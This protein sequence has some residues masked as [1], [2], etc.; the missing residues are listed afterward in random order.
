M[1]S[2]IDRYDQSALDY[3]CYWAPVLDA[4]S[5]RLLD[6][7][8]DHMAG[9]SGRQTI[10]DVGAGT[11]ALALTAA[12]RW[13]AA[14]VIVSDAA[15][16]MLELARQ[17]LTQAADVEPGRLTF[18]LAPA[19]EL[20]LADGSVDLVI[21]SFVLQ[22]VPDR[23]AAL[24]EA[25][26]VLRP[27]GVLAYVTWLDRE[28]S[29]PFEPMYEFDEAVLDLGIDEP[30]EEPE[31]HAGDVL[32]AR[33]AADQ[34]RRAGFRSVSAREDELV[35]DWTAESYL[36]YKLA[37]D[38]RALLSLLDERQRRELE[39]NARARLARLAPAEFRWYAPIVF[40]RGARPLG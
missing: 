14:A 7:V 8:S 31:A 23:L 4:T 25:Y 36:E 20:P 22:L 19:A 21:S 30:E 33:A 15:A 39:A 29:Q 16:G 38:E 26:R 28:S 24:R 18:T 37:Y 1:S 35:H 27:A 6:E 2:I 12:E 13:P 3:A 17:R 34:L 5:R 40:A 9:Q 10:L 11:G 32:S